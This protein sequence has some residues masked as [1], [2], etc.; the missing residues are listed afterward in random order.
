MRPQEKNHTKIKAVETAPSLDASTVA[1]SLNNKNLSQE[2]SQEEKKSHLEINIVV[3]TDQYQEVE[4]IYGNKKIRKRIT[5]FLPLNF[6][7]II[8][9]TAPS[10]KVGAVNLNHLSR[11]ASFPLLEKFL[12]ILVKISHISEIKTAEKIWDSSERINTAEK[13]TLLAFI[14][15]WRPEDKRLDRLM[16][17]QKSGEISDRNSF[18]TFLSEI[19]ILTKNS[20]K[21]ADFLF[22][23]FAG[24]LPAEK[25]SYLTGC[26]RNILSEADDSKR[27]HQIKFLQKIVNELSG[28]KEN[29][30]N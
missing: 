23:D 3:T 22:K 26:L 5:K 4:I 6:A 16:V 8:Y 25:K 2:S 1:L 18:E 12:N 19:V 10:T 11:G 7:N 28:T 20:E 29:S 17:S 14:N 13:A 9:P 24:S 27:D 21:L 30:K 15:H